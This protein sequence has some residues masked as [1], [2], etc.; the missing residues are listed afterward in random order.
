[1]NQHTTFLDECLKECLLM[2]Q[3]L[4]MVLNKIIWSCSYFAEMVLTYTNNVKVEDSLLNQAFSSDSRAK[5]YS[6]K[7]QAK[8][9]EESSVTGKVLAKKR[10]N[11]MVEEYSKRF[12]EM[13]KTFLQI[14]HQSRSRSEVHL[15]NLVIRLDYNGFYSQ[16]LL[17]ERQ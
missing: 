1:M 17:G 2:D 14:I 3:E 9:K 12:D 15:I 5:T 11:L 6:E 10:Y 8:I 4:F 16:K 7:R 13:L